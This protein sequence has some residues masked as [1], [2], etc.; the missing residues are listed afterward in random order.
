L[1]KVSIF[2]LFGAERINSQAG[3]LID[4]WYVYLNQSICPTIVDT[5]TPTSTVNNVGGSCLSYTTGTTI[6]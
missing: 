5:G 1:V 6:V 4:Q 2:S 3:P